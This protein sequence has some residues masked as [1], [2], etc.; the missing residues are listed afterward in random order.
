MSWLFTRS[1]SCNKFGKPL[2]FGCVSKVEVR[3]CKNSVPASM[4]IDWNKQAWSTDGWVE[5][6]C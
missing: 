5:S 6:L 1:C 4:L 2:L 3:S